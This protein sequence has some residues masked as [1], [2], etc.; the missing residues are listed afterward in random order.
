[1]IVAGL[2]REG[3]RAR[4]AGPCGEL[5]AGDPPAGLAPPGTSG[6]KRPDST[7]KGLPTS[8]EITPHLSAQGAA[9]KR[10]LA[11]TCRRHRLGLSATSSAAVVWRTSTALYRQ[12]AWTPLHRVKSARAQLAPTVGSCPGCRSRARSAST[13]TSLRLSSEPARTCG[14]EDGS[15]PRNWLTT[16]RT[17]A[18]GGRLPG[19]RAR[20]PRAPQ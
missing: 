9:R 4:R 19:T 7:V 20:R 14:R 18:G 2:F 6:G 12:G 1:M 10:P 16:Y 3:D 15:L 11:L 13:R 17:F 8:G 5:I